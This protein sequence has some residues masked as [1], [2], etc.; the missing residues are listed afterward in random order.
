VTD[1]NTITAAEAEAAA[2]EALAASDQKT[3]ET[4]ARRRPE[5]EI[6]TGAKRNYEQ[7]LANL[8]AHDADAID[9]YDE[10]RGGLIT[11]V[12]ITALAS[13]IDGTDELAVLGAIFGEAYAS[14]VQDVMTDIFMD[15][16]NESPHPQ[17]R[18]GLRLRLGYPV[19]TDAP[20]IRKDAARRISD[21]D[22]L[23]M[24]PGAVE[25]SDRDHVCHD[26][27]VTIPA[28]ERHLV[29]ADGD[30]RHSLTA[31]WCHSVLGDVALARAILPEI[32][33]LVLPL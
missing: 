25:V 8:D 16:S 28:G 31:A 3:A 11:E 10:L 17:K 5:D 4:L 2:E 29:A 26:S 1:P 12:S 33:H 13:R 30:T 24:K 14:P 23:A 22:L 6:P 32:P 18:I 27:G 15:R 19:P 20:L 7:W 9:I 21:A